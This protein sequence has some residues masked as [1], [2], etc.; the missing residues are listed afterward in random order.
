MTYY[1]DLMGKVYA[2]LRRQRKLTQAQLAAKLG[3]NTS[4]ISRIETGKS[5]LNVPQHLHICQILKV[6]PAVPFNSY[7]DQVDHLLKQQG[8]QP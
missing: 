8:V 3:L 5:S 4:A 1:P 7:G 2:R 6:H